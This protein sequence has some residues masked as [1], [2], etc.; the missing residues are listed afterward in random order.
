[1]M[2]KQPTLTTTRLILRPFK[3]TDAK[4]VKLYA[5]DKR[6]ADVTLN[7]PHPYPDGAAEQ[8]I[9]THEK[10]FKERNGVVYAI[11]QKTAQ[12]IIGSIG[13]HN[14][15]VSD[16]ELGYWVGVPYWS[17]GYCTEA[18]IALLDFCFEQLQLKRVYCHHMTR[19]PAS[20]RVMQKAKMRYM[21][22]EVDA[23][24]KN[25]VL[26]TVEHY[27]MLRPRDPESS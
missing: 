13:I 16:G 24:E 12:D 8:W 14:M 5:G 3:L 26:E 21:G 19:N 2:K 18:S 23:I 17:L 7:I 20:G 6:V 10:V 25:G 15:T 1:M 11:T 22:S 4:L 27:E 9:R